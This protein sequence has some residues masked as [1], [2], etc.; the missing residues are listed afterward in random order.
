MDLRGGYFA[1][2]DAIACGTGTNSSFTTAPGEPPVQAAMHPLVRSEA[3]TPQHNDKIGSIPISSSLCLDGKHLS[4]MHTA[5][6][7]A[8]PDEE[9]G[10]TLYPA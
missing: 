1:T 9:H 7:T 4:M 8:V 6:G 5:T 3:A 2:L 10:E